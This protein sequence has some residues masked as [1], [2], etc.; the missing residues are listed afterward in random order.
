LTKS[1]WI[2]IEVF[3]KIL[4]KSPM[5]QIKK[6]TDEHRGTLI[7]FLREEIEAGKTAD[8]GLKKEAWASIVGKFNAH[9]KIIA[10]KSQLQSQLGTVF[11]FI[12]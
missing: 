6:F 7:G 9:W 8:N 5:E 10:Q 2:E 3:D 11:I 4:K 12:L 1:S